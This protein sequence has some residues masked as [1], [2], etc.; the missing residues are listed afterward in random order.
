MVPVCSAASENDW[1]E[2]IAGLSVPPSDHKSLGHIITQSI[3][4]SNA[5]CTGPP[6]TVH[7]QQCALC[8]KVIDLKEITTEVM[9]H[10]QSF[11]KV[12]FTIYLHCVIF[13]V[14]VGEKMRRLL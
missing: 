2:L 8:S 7:M 14:L 11:G 1:K 4:F 9:Q 13:T 12:Y 10:F 5:Y 6:L 3:D